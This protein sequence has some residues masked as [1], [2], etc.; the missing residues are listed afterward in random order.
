VGV[1]EGANRESPHVVSIA[2]KNQPVTCKAAGQTWKKSEMQ[3]LKEQL[4]GQRVLFPLGVIVISR[5][6]AAQLLTIDVTDALSRHAQGDWGD[7]CEEDR[8]S[9]ERALVEHKPLLSAYHA[10]NGNRFCIT[11]EGDRS[12]T[13]IFLPEDY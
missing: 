6:A 3:Q 9:N 2:E 8:L 12:V 13:T 10:S 5:N 11:T 1:N 4:C 7:L